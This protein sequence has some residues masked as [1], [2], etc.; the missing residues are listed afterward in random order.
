MSGGFLHVFPAMLD[1]AN[2]RS[3]RHTA[4]LLRKWAG[5]R[6]KKHW[7]SNW[8]A[9][10]AALDPWNSQCLLGSLTSDVH[11]PSIWILSFILKDVSDSGWRKTAA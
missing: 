9:A 2:G 1:G 5:E 8:A 3:A 11:G 4:R 10:A 6:G 7:I